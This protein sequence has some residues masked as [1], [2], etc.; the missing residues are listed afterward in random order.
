MS[1]RILILG[2]GT[3]QGVAIQT[4]K[5]RGWETIVIDGNPNAPCRA[6]ADR[7]EPIDLKDVPAI[8]SF[9][10][11]LHRTIG[12]DGVF[13]AATDFSVSVAAAATACNLPS[14]SLE[15]A[16]DASDKLR[17]RARFH[18]A[19]V[20]SPKCIGVGIDT[21]PTVVSQLTNAHISFPVVVKPVD[22]MGSRGCVRV[23]SAD[24]LLDACRDALGF[25]RTG[26][27]IIEEYM[28]GPEYSLEALVFD[29]KFYM[30]G[31]ADRHIFF[32]PYFVEMGHTIPTGISEADRERLI[33]VFRAGAQALGLT[34][35]AAKGDIKLTPKG[36][37]VGEIAA[38]LSGGYMSGWTFPYSSGIDV[39]GAALDLAVGNR[40]ASLDPL[41]NLVCAERAWI[42][43][44]GKISSVSGI[45]AAAAMPGIKNIFPRV[46]VGDQVSFPKNNVEKCGNCLSIHKNR[47]EAISQAQHACAAVIIRLAAPNPQTDAFLAADMDTPFPPSAFPNLRVNNETNFVNQK[48]SKKLFLPVPENLVSELDNSIDWQGRTLRQAIEQTIVYEP[49]LVKILVE[50]EK[51]NC[52]NYWQALLRGGIQGIVYVYDREQQ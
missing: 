23:N 15:A 14:H 6:L 30:T 40:P 50:S 28:E 34:H 26:T 1:K 8:V 52:V 46:G 32:P 43:L 44:P 51:K 9:A 38:R 13:T 2:A 27:A 19:N 12:L 47:E 36:P 4:A 33:S 35:G 25:S 10:Q 7:F 24:S 20:P 16:K 37:M 5:D 29:G 39:T 22:N 21:L 18:V 3:M 31:F 45:E 41:H 42:S 11:E 17:M 49:N 48:F